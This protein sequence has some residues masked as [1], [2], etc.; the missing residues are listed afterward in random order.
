MNQ[1]K[2]Y[3]IMIVDDQKVNLKIIS[4]LL[5]TSGFN[6]ITAE[7][8]KILFEKLENKLPDLILLDIIIPEMDGFE[9][10]YR[11]QSSEKT[12]HIP[13]IFM[14]SISEYEEKIRGLKLGAVDYIT[15]PVKKEEVVARINIHLRLKEEIQE[16]TQ[17]E[18]E[19]Q[20]TQVE[21]EKMI[22][23]RTA[24]LSRSLAELQETQIELIKSEQM[25]SI[26]KLITGIAHELNNP[27]SIVLGNINLAEQYL[28]TIINHIKL[29]QK[30]FPHPGSIIEK[31]A[32]EM[33]IDFLI[34]ELPKMLSSIK[35]A[36]DRISET[37]VSLR[38]LARVDSMSKIPFD[39]NDAIESNLKILQH[40]LK[41]NSQRP[42]IKIV[43]KYGDLPKINCYP[44]ALNYVLM[45]LLVNS[46][47]SVE[48]FNSKKNRSYQEIWQNQNCINIT[49]LVIESYRVKI[50]IADNGLG[51]LAHLKNK[52]DEAIEGVKSTNKRNTLGLSMSHSIIVEKHR[53]KLECRSL[54]NQGKEFIIELPT[55]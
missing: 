46:I 40:R 2:E 1:K 53:G 21:L 51:M 20:K 49:T 3:T 10:C 28:E 19:L 5:K 43:K 50:I 32:E 23:E 11:L 35:L 24:K 36:S 52:L 18:I 33:D 54:P 38:S 12:K 30:E 6:V 55:T 9:I 22:E 48:E 44:H 15:K 37:S 27:V 7:R 13:I 34:E 26:G 31:D 14:T 29:Y 16:R 25:S 4:S 41:A 47:D 42:E 45:N 8:G 39:I 17:A